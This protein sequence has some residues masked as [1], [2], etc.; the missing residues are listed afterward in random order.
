MPRPV[1]CA[2][3][4]AEGPKPATALAAAALAVA[5]GLGSVDAARA[6]IAGLTPCSESKAFAKREKN[7]L[8]ALEKRMKQVPT[9]HVPR[10]SALPVGL[11]RQKRWVLTSLCCHAV[12]AGQCAGAGSVCHSRADQVPLLLLRQG[13]PSVRD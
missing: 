1:V 3:Q 12:R 8:K 13:W 5:L 11:P 6:D 7:E 2:A 9:R 4:R 10:R